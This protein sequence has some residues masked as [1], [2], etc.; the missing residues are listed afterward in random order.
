LTIPEIASRA[1]VSRETFYEMYPTKQDV[2]VGAQKVGMH[3]ALGVGVKAF[4]A[5]MPDW[6]RAIAAGVRALIAYLVSEPAH[7]HLSIVDAF[8]AS[9]ETIKVRDETLTAFATY[10]R[11]G[12]ELARRDTGIPAI[13]ADA[14]VGG[15]WQVLHHEIDD[16]RFA[17]LSEATPSLI[18]LLLT[19]FIGPR[20][21]AKVALEPTAN[22]ERGA[23]SDDNGRRERA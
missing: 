1:G 7:A 3:Q 12:Y 22:G 15:A 4:E 20:Q 2:F 21:A 19:P 11:R 9:P 18:Y 5:A 17:E 16:E 8:G 10:F 13:A 23:G 14:V 6:P